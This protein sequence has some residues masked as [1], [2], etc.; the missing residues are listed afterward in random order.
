[1]YLH[2]S[3]CFGYFDDSKQKLE[4]GHLIEIPVDELPPQT[5]V[6]LLH[7][8]R[9]MKKL[10]FEYGMFSSTWLVVEKMYPPLK[11]HI[12]I[13][14]EHVIVFDIEYLP[15]LIDFHNSQA[16]DYVEYN[17]EYKMPDLK[18]QHL[19]SIL[20]DMND[21]ISENMNLF[22]IKPKSLCDWYYRIATNQSY[23]CPRNISS[24]SLCIMQKDEYDLISTKL[25]A[26]VSAQD[27]VFDFLFREMKMDTYSGVDNW[28]KI[29]SEMYYFI[30]AY[31]EP[32]RKES[33][34]NLKLKCW[35][36]TIAFLWTFPSFQHMSWE[37]KNKL[38]EITI[39]CIMDK[40]PNILMKMFNHKEHYDKHRQ[41]KLLQK[42]VENPVLV[43]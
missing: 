10:N 25:S 18:D 13:D 24:K 26:K 41:V 20:G 31:L 12:E 15:R 17:F 7:T 16:L 1:M 39:D 40:T 34:L 42:M 37:T 33:Q 29:H 4:V 14:S 32:R 19:V 2:Y 3:P 35:Y 8:L 6:V 28:K 30:V 22:E 5:V 36:Q 9:V 43:N 21:Y 27:S 11:L 23:H 38:Y